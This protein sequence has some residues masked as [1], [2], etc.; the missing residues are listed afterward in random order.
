MKQIIFPI[1]DG[2]LKLSGGHQVLRTSTLIWDHLNE[3][4]NVKS[5]RRSRRVSTTTRLI[6]GCR[7]SAKRCVV[8]FRKLH[9]PPSRWTECQS[10]HAERGIIPNPNEIFWRSQGYTY[11][12]GC[13]AGRPNRWLL[14]HLWCQRSIRFLDSF[15][16]IYFIR[17]QTSRWIYTFSKERLT[18]RQATS[19]PDHSWPE[20]WKDMLKASK[21]KEKQKWASENIRSSTMPDSWGYIL[22]L[23]RGRRFQRDC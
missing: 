13:T 21:Q 3:E 4:K 8:D 16:T 19:R 17:R 9:L 6:S 22:H 11:D 23:S 2:K 15:H 14:E 1:A 10:S 20:V 12:L 7:C 5:S 18:K